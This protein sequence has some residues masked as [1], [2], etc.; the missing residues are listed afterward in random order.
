MILGILSD[1]HDRAD[2]MSAAISALQNAGAKFFIHCGDVGGQQI[3][4]QLAGLSAAFVWGN[5]DFDRRTLAAYAQS[6]N[7]QCLDSF[8]R[9]ELAGKSIAIT[10]G[11]DLRVIK[12]VLAEQRDDYLL[13][14][15]THVHADYR[16]GKVRVINPGAL[17]R[18]SQKTVATVD[19]ASNEL[20]FHRV[21]I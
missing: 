2:A 12:R 5:N 6:L 11:D 18:A 1:T 10:H 4:D 20:K 13:L 9:I 7:I 3:I 21:T 17:Y 16:S 8:G 19:L 15:H 14:G